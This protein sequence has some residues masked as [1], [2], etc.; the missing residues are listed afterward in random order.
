MGTTRF[1]FF[2]LKWHCD[3]GVWT[4]LILSCLLF[5][6]V[7]PLLNVLSCLCQT[8]FD[9]TPGWDASTGLGTPNLGNLIAAIDAMD[10]KREAMLR[11]AQTA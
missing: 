3:D 11:A 6:F 5:R 7:S 1:E 2:I 10:E 9:A 4:R 8:G